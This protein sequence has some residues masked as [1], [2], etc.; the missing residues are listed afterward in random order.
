MPSKTATEVL[1]LERYDL[2]RMRAEALAHYVTAT[3]L[4]EGFGE[5]AESM[6]HVLVEKFS[7][8]GFEVMTDKRR[9]ELGLPPRGPDGWTDAEI[10]ALDKRRM[11]L[12]TAVPT[13]TVGVCAKCGGFIDGG[14]S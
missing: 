8:E 10:A 14:R 5:L 6:F 13:V 2:R 12:L 11:D 7:K 9:D 4:R 3:L 1:Q